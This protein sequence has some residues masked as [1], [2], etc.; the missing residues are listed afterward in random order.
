MT[1]LENSERLP[2][3]PM[4]PSIMTPLEVDW[5]LRIVSSSLAIAMVF[6]LFS[7]TCFCCFLNTLGFGVPVGD[8]FFDSMTAPGHHPRQKKILNSTSFTKKKFQY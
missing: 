8:A 5:Q 6:N 1:T 4:E 2:S 7:F 3:I